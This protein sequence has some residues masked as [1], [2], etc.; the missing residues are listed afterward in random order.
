MLCTAQQ[1]FQKIQKRKRGVHHN[2]D[3]HILTRE[4]MQWL[5]AGIQALVNGSYTPQHLQRYY[6]KDAIVEQ[7]EIAD[8]VFQHVLLKQLKP[9]FKHLI[10]P[11]CLHL[12]GPSGVK[13]ATLRIRQAL[14]N[15]DYRYIIRADIKSYY[16]SIPHHQL[17]QDI[18]QCFDDRNVQAMLERVITNPI[19]TPW[20]YKNPDRGIALR[21]PLS[22][23]FSAIYLKPL[24]D[25]FNQAD[26]TYVRFQDDIIILCKTK[27]QLDR[28]RQ[29][30]MRVL[31]ERR[32]T[33]SRKK[34]RIGCINSGFH[35]LGIDYPRTQTAGNTTEARS[36]VGRLNTSD[37]GHILI[38]GGETVQHPA[39]PLNELIKVTPHAR[40]L[41]KA[42]IQV[43]L[44]VYDGFTAQKISTYLKRYCQ[45]WVRT[46]GTWEYTQLLL[47]FMD[48]CW[49]ARVLAYANDLLRASKQLNPD[50]GLAPLLTAPP[51][52]VDSASS[53][54]TPP[55][56]SHT[57]PSGPINRDPRTG[58]ICRP[59]AAPTLDTGQRTTTRP[60][61]ILKPKTQNQAL[62]P[63]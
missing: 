31:R 3:I 55:D 28:C 18:K 50:R 27:R 2:H 53:R 57:R 19:E 41:R 51:C 36:E 12:Q 35:F 37:D 60:N 8:R 63:A 38:G 9:T 17:V 39:E 4:V 44:M 30:M 29:Q 6:F 26:V 49:D 32:L 52:R 21:G 40:T 46:S 16:T 24:D 13:Y 48:V 1:V 7:L 42:R 20:G 56:F 59:S 33:L 22:Q 61:L 10:N 45:W 25:A 54:D 5:P 62:P 34:S 43:Q 15:N 23:L 11:N 47:W 58:P 14:Q